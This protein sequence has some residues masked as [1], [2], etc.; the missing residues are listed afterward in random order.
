METLIALESSAKVWKVTAAWV[1]EG[2]AVWMMKV[3]ETSLGVTNV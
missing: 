2:A 1:E 3:T